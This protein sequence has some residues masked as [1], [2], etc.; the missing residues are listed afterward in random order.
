MK[1]Y[2]IRPRISGYSND[3]YWFLQVKFMGVWISKAS[4]YK[5]DEAVK[6]MNTLIL[7]DVYPNK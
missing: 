6:V 4:Y 2:R 5:L 3:L 7:G 1:K